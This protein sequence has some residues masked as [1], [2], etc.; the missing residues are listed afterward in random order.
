MLNGCYSQVQA[1]AI[2]MHVPY[3]IGMKDAVSD[4]AAIEFAVGFYD[5]LGSGESISFAFEMGKVAM[6]LNGTGDEE[7]PLLLGQ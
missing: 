2:V 6:A 1:E 3:V 4:R 7:M 5:A